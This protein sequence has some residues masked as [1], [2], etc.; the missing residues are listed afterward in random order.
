MKQLK[1]IDEFA[2]NQLDRNSQNEIQGGIAE[3]TIQGCVEY[4][5]VRVGL[6]DMHQQ[7]Q[8]D[9]GTPISDATVYYPTFPWP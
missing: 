6:G 8:K 5:Q 4:T 1:K 7:Q 2:K 9:D 3:T